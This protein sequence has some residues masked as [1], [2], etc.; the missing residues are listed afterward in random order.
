MW[1]WQFMQGGSGETPGLAFNV[2]DGEPCVYR[3]W[4]G[5]EYLAVLS[6]RVEVAEGTAGEE[7]IAAVATRLREECVRVEP[8]ATR[9]LFTDLVTLARGRWWE[10]RGVG[11]R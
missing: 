7:V 2:L 5:D 3:A 8:K 1:I 4:A 6:V 10:G 11:L 9:V